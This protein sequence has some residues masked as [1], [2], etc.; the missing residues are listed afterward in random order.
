MRIV[1]KIVLSN[2]YGIRETF[3]QFR[4]VSQ[5]HSHVILRIKSISDYLDY[6]ELIDAK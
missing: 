1:S 5:F 4:F 6:G 3:P 2:K